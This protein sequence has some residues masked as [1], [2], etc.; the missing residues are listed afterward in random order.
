MSKGPDNQNRADYPTSNLKDVR[1]TFDMEELHGFAHEIMEIYGE[2]EMFSEEERVLM[3][4]LQKG[5]GE[6]LSYQSAPGQYLVVLYQQTVASLLDRVL[7]LINS[8]VFEEVYSMLESSV[9]GDTKLSEEEVAMS[10]KHTH[11]IIAPFMA[12][13]ALGFDRKPAEFAKENPLPM[14][15]DSADISVSDWKINLEAGENFRHAMSGI[16]SVSMYMPSVERLTDT[17]RKENNERDRKL[18]SNLKIQVFHQLPFLIPILNACNKKI[19]GIDERKTVNVGE[20]LDRVAGGVK[21]RLIFSYNLDEVGQTI[22]NLPIVSRV[23]NPDQVMEGVDWAQMYQA[24]L[25]VS[26]NAVV[27]KD[28]VSAQEIKGYIEREEPYL[29]MKA[30]EAEINGRTVSVFQF[31]DKGRHIDIPGVVAKMGDM[32]IGW[33]SRDITLGQ[34]LDFLSERRISIPI[35]GANDSNIERSIFTGIGLHSARST[36]QAHNG[37]LFPVNT[38]E[39]V[40]FMVIFPREGKNADWKVSEEKITGVDCGE[41]SKQILGAQEEL[42][43]E[44]GRVQALGE[45]PVEPQSLEYKHTQSATHL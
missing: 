34:M 32:L 38:P 39:G 29:V 21:A 26:K 14:P 37:E 31:S 42:R 40:V 44:V 33:E 18:L 28:K 12:I 30:G 2:C 10:K 20:L 22:E 8:G 15:F 1:E 41:I 4:Q 25:E 16:F 24:F 23:E 7:T 13:A 3:E 19:T 17:S 45:P 6:S 36:I 27:R 35:K 11:E 5:L 43:A 9:E